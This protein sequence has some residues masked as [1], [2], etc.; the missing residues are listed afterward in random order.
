MTPARVL[1][2]A[3]ALGVAGA[4]TAKAPPAKT[5]TSPKHAATNW[6]ETYAATPDGGFQRG[7]P[8]ARV[9]LIEY[10]SLTCPHCRAFHGEAMP[11]LLSKYVASGKLSYEYRSFLL[12]PPDYAAALL[13][14]CSGN[15][16]TFFSAL[17]SFYP[18][19]P[20][21]T[22]PFINLSEADS[23]RLSETPEDK[24]IAALAVVGKLDIYAAKLGMNRARFDACVSDKAAA[25]KLLDMRKVATE[26][27]KVSGTPGFLINGVYQEKV[28]DWAALQPL[29]DAALKS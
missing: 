26:T 27:Y 11:T 28:Y 17:N 19:Q 22:Q 29:L 6:T 5:P 13:A 24:R 14:R 25:D 20:E 18:D 1:L 12:N 9:K 15:A 4:A 7:N 23:K 2:A 10:G 21:W 3:L 16:K 8:N